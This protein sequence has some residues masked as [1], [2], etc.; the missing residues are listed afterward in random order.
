[1]FNPGDENHINDKVRVVKESGKSYVRVRIPFKRFWWS[2]EGVHP[3]RVDVQVHK[4]DG[5]T[6]S[7]CPN[8]PL[9]ER[10][11]F[12]TDNP[13]DLGWLMFRN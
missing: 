5:G 4:R 3:L 10:L 12:G 7:W 9:T 1:V 2:E 13:A 6:S 11:V 8:N